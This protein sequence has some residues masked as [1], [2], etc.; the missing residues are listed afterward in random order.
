MRR[1]LLKTSVVIAATLF[2]LLLAEA[3]LRLFFELSG[4][5][6][7]AYQPPPFTTCNSSA[8]S[9]SPIWSSLTTA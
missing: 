7:N 3:A 4:R 1:L 6:I 9:S 5:D 8:S 2:A